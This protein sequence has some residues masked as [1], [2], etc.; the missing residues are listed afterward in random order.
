[1]TL[2]EKRKTKMTL[3]DRLSAEL[4]K[5]G[6]ITGEQLETAREE[7]KRTGETLGQVLVKLSFL[8][9]DQLVSFLARRLDLPQV[10]L[11]SYLVDPEVINQVPEKLARRYKIIPLFQVENTLT[12]A[13][14]DPLNV[15]AL[16]EIR[17]QT[18]REVEPVIS[19]EPN[20]LRAIDQYYSAGH[21]IQEAVE[22]L[23]K[24][25]T[26]VT[27][28]EDL[29][30]ERLE[31]IA[32]QPPVMKLVNQIILQAVRD[33]ASD[34]HIEPEKDALGVRYRIDGILH[35]VSS[36]PKELHLPIVSRIKVMANLDIVERRLPQDGRIQT[37]V[38]GRDID[39]RVSTFPTIHGEKVVLRVLDK[40]SMSFSLADLGFSPENLQKFQSLI[41]R[42]Y[43]VILI[44]GPTG[45]G[46]T[47]T[48][49]AALNAINFPEKNI[50]T[51]E[52]PVEYQIKNISQGQIN[53]KVGLHFATGLRAIL[54]QDPDI[55]MVGEVRDYETA[56]LVVRAAL[57]GHLVFST[58][59]TN[60]APGALTRLT[61]MGVEPFLISSSVTG[62][63]AQRLV[64]TICPF[65]KQETKPSPDLLKQIELPPKAEAT[66]FKGK[67]CP[68]CKRTG[69]KG[70]IGIFELLLISDRIR[71][72]IMSKTSSSVI[73]EAAR[74][75]G[76]KTL[77]ED[78][79]EKALKG[80]TTIEEVLR[81]TQVGE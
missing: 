31:R 5:D 72:L 74:E 78:G 14:A 9:E 7:Q 30:G 39:L 76:L 12:V 65:C 16:D 57:T 75:M 17:F 56:E 50:I 55:I 69:Y 47:S 40:S 18:G 61:D 6:L 29:G 53:P 21:L 70:R 38:E 73:K 1:M 52:E 64:R 77:Q 79:L 36:P 35:K 49:Y 67:G 68:K 60:D 66:F 32:E 48:L 51:V 13:M 33:K 8:T 11:S 3:I 71:E 41:K 59:H 4:V 28:D 46:K 42:S 45:S 37:S 22:D 44:T 23:D 15:F 54:R 19:T 34:I 63:V 43:G 10:D 25:V 80:I 20:I 26:A 2:A 58:L 62:V 81:V 27:L 24:M